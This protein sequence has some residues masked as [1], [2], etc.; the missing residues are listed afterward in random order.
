MFFDSGSTD[1]TLPSSLCSDDNCGSK[2]R[3]SVNTSASA[4]SGGNDVVSNFA[5]GSASKGAWIKDTVTAGGLTSVQSIVAATE[6]SATIK[7]L[8]SDGL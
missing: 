3:Y 4:V 1:L 2:A 5:D 7:S 8:D 6:L